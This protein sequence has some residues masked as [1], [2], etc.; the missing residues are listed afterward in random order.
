MFAGMNKESFFENLFDQLGIPASSEE[1]DVRNAVQSWQTRV[2]KGFIHNES[3]A[4]KI[5]EIQ[6]KAFD[7][8]YRLH[9]MIVK[10]G[11]G[12]DQLDL[13]LARIRKLVGKSGTPVSQEWID[14]LTSLHVVLYR[15]E[16]CEFLLEKCPLTQKD[17]EEDR[18]ILTE[19]VE[20]FFQFFMDFHVQCVESALKQHERESAFEH[21]RIVS[22]FPDL[23]ESYRRQ[24]VE[25]MMHYFV[26]YAD[27]LTAKY[28]VVLS[29]IQNEKSRFQARAK[30]SK[31]ER[32]SREALIPVY[33]LIKKHDFQEQPPILEKTENFVR[34]LIHYLQ[35]NNL[36]EKSNF[37]IQE[38]SDA[39][40]DMATQPMTPVVDKDVS[41]DA[42]KV[43]AELGRLVEEGKVRQAKA[44][45]AKEKQGR[46]P[47][48]IAQAFERIS[49]DPFF[50]VNKNSKTRPGA[51]TFSSLGPSGCVNE[52]GDRIDIRWLKLGVPLFPRKAFVFNKENQC[53]GEVTLPDRFQKIQV[54]LAILF[55]LVGGYLFLTLRGLQVRESPSETA[56]AKLT[57]I[58]AMPRFERFV[59]IS[60]FLQNPDYRQTEYY[61]EAIM[62][63]Y[64]VTVHLFNAYREKDRIG[65]FLRDIGARTLFLGRKEKI[66]LMHYLFPP[67]M[68][69]LE[70]DGFQN[71]NLIEW[72]LKMGGFDLGTRLVARQINWAVEN[73][74]P[75]V[76][77]DAID[78]GRKYR[79]RISAKTLNRLIDHELIHP[80]EALVLC[81][82][83]E[84][85]DRKYWKRAFLKIWGGQTELTLYECN[86]LIQKAGDAFPDLRLDLLAI[87][88]DE[89]KKK[90]YDEQNTWDQVDMR[91]KHPVIEK[92]VK[93]VVCRFLI[94]RGR[95]DEMRTLAETIPEE[96][97]ND[98]LYHLRIPVLFHQNKP[99]HVIN[100]LESY[101]K[102]R[103][104]GEYDRVLLGLSYIE[105]NRFEEGRELLQPIVRERFEDYVKLWDKLNRRKDV[106]RK[107]V[108]RQLK[109]KKG[110]YEPVARKIFLM[111][112]DNEADRAREDFILG[113]IDADYTVRM[114]KRGIT[115]LDYIYD[116]IY[117]LIEVYIHN[118]RAKML[119]SARDM[120]LELRNQF[121][122]YDTEILLGR[123]F[124]LL[125][126]EKGGR[127]IFTEVEDSC[128]ERKI[129]A[130]LI[131]LLETYHR[132]GFQ[133][134]I[135]KLSRYIFRKCDDDLD[136]LARAARTLYRIET[137][138]DEKL[139]WL[140]KI[141]NKTLEDEI[142]I[143][144]LKIEIDKKK[145]DYSG[146]LRGYQELL[147][148]SPRY[149]AAVEK[150]ELLKMLG[151]GF[152]EFYRLGNSSAALD[153]AVTAFERVSRIEQTN[154]VILNKFLNVLWFRTLEKLFPGADG[155]FLITE[156]DLAFLWKA[157][158]IHSTE[159]R[160][161]K[162]IQ[163]LA[164]SPDFLRCRKLFQ[165]ILGLNETF[166]VLPPGFFS[167]LRAEG[168]PLDFLDEID[169]DA[170]SRV[171]ARSFLQFWRLPSVMQN[172]VLLKKL[173]EDVESAKKAMKQVPEEELKAYAEAILNWAEA[174]IRQWVYTDEPLKMGF[175]KLMERVA[176]SSGLNP[177]LRARRLLL[178]I[179]LM[180]LAFW[181][182]P[183]K[184]FLRSMTPAWVIA[185][186]RS[187]GQTIK[188]GDLSNI[189]DDVRELIPRYRPFFVDD[190]VLLL[191]IKEGADLSVVGPR[192]RRLIEM[193][194][195]LTA[196]EYRRRVWD[197]LL[198][199]IR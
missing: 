98:F 184:I 94:R 137:R 131:K 37:L 97:E 50:F 58:K 176:F 32:D 114:I 67:I 44:L 141:K 156:S 194:K 30:L 6:H 167:L 27:G 64:M 14:V 191:G 82:S 10:G 160:A 109:L 146:M 150:L 47:P 155:L 89:N 189:M 76:V 142:R 18:G 128:I 173:D 31:L 118:N 125:G 120:L 41:G 175:P 36:S 16:F 170:F 19:L 106:V 130:P 105:K 181:Y 83:M 24:F 25:R 162:T 38:M 65:D 88:L 104:L 108:R 15:D 123:V 126:K 183:E 73:K 54:L 85:I 13:Q 177:T 92:R 174:V 163:H 68:E 151:D 103:E 139:H 182:D 127:D 112:D 165:R 57:A 172:P 148:Q 133:E 72:A 95:F 154:P 171:E 99:I 22:D 55:V 164:T 100:F 193:E 78:I 161:G 96:P 117:G 21:F 168:P 28:S 187:R 49:N 60:E 29:E 56:Q 145:G 52:K 91:F 11:F 69:A 74:K 135:K 129:Y 180:K 33:E 113:E 158:D 195:E 178:E 71:E 93:L 87:L 132:I 196:Y 26:A 159:D 4:E 12:W 7:K 53:L 199:R 79:I 43:L 190:L 169:P 59:P 34:E 5:R 115:E 101:R 45:F 152:F 153:R 51:T 102:N 157:V 81:E 86:L 63:F 197:D 62:E 185:R 48:E 66:K 149:L 3:E 80:N 188:K 140:K 186:A 138:E 1:N 35:T 90:S 77:R 121:F 192:E 70:K 111:Q 40:R 61:P 119:R 143:H 8:K 147:E 166:F 116:S 110:K 198:Q 17:S 23:T 84:D 144:F 46:H 134:E 124:L 107:Y 136:F 9:S 42:G 20:E 39:P 2:E 122:D 179:E 75:D